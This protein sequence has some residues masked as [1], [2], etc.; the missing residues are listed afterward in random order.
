VVV[1][2]AEDGGGQTA[3]FVQQHTCSEV[4]FVAATGQLRVRCPACRTPAIG[5]GLGAKHDLLFTCTRCQTAT[6]LDRLDWRHSAGY[7]R[8][9]I[10][11]GGVHAHEALPSD[12]LLAALQAFSGT[13]WRHFYA[14]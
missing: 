3:C 2:P 1:D 4:S 6:P 12:R 11:I 9:F 13:G 14:G 8:Y 5:I 7:G 10:E